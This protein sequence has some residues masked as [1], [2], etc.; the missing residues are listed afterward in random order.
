MFQFGEGSQRQSVRL[1]PAISLAE[2]YLIS[3]GGCPKEVNF[4]G[5]FNACREKRGNLYDMGRSTTVNWK[6][7][8]S[9]DDIA[10][11]KTYNITG[12]GATFVYDTMTLGWQG[13][14]GSE[15]ASINQTL[16]ALLQSFDFTIVGQFGLRPQP[17]NF[18]DMLGFN[19][20]QDNY[21]MKL[22]KRNLIASLSYGY[23]VGAKYRKHFLPAHFRFY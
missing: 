13:S 11:Y 7:N 15:Q 17:T 4:T 21:F 9:L 5:G 20:G 2:T 22:K 3:P 10:A 19:G 18:S 16:L 14:P 1:L 8:Y 12:Q 6:S 23:T